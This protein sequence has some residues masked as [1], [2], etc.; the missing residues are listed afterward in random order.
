MQGVIGRS[1][2]S[3]TKVAR[4]L[5]Y[6]TLFEDKPYAASIMGSFRTVA[7]ITAD[8]LRNHHARFYSPENMIMSI[9]T[10]RAIPEVLGWVERTFGR[11]ASSGLTL[12]AG[13]TADPLTTVKKAHVDLDKEQIGIYLGSV[14][15]GANSD[16]A[17][18][19]AVATSIL[20]SRLYLNLRE[21]QGLAYSTGAGSRFDPEFGW[22]YCTIGTS[23]ENYQRALDGLIL[24]INK[25][26][27][28]GPTV[29]EVA[30]ARNSL[31]GRLMSAKLSRI[32]QAYYLAVNN[33]LG[34]AVGHDKEFL[35]QLEQVTADSVRRVASQ[36][37]R[38][39]NYVLATAGKIP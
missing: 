30:Q 1:A 10:N 7:S 29:R 25:L 34:R 14:L 24:Q 20:S 32:N 2:G 35:K 27:L 23:A 11:M 31:W 37:F 22:Y 5:F 28:D 36:H 6:Q 9:A 19:L 15:P 26:K 12:P 13:E 38:T 16:D 33:Y 8:D 18:A 21:K 3:P 17:A 39:D 4:D